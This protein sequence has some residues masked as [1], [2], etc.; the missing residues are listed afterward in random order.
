MACSNE[1]CYW[2]QRV[3]E[4][5]EKMNQLRLSRRILLNL[6]EKLEKENHRLHS[7]NSR[8][9]RSLMLKNIKIVEMESK[10]QK[11]IIDFETL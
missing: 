2:R 8:Y 4:L 6:L 9:A 5:E 3:R 11:S 7:V 1:M 10:H